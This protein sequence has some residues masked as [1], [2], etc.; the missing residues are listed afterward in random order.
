MFRRHKDLWSHLEALV[1]REQVTSIV[2]VGPGLYSPVR[3]WVRSYLA[4]DINPRVEAIHA[5]FAT[6]D[7]SALRCWDMVLVANVINHCAEYH[8][9]LEQIQ[10]INPRL[11][12]VTLFDLHPRR[13]NHRTITSRLGPLITRYSERRLRKDLDRYY[14][15]DWQIERLGRHDAILTLRRRD[16]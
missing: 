5:D 11:A 10:R 6:M 12:A 7:V 2:E 1:R 3:D 4:I 8:S 9:F 15:W 16:D 14:P 13:V